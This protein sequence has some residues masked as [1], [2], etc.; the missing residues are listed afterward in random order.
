[1]H[2][3]KLVLRNFKK[4]RRAEIDFQDG[5]T[6]I[7]GSNGSGKSTIVEAIAWALYGN[8]VST[9]RREYLKNAHAGASE[10]VE[11]SLWLNWG[12]Q[13]MQVT[14]IMR[15]KS[16]SP[17]AELRL[18]G[19]PVAR[20][21]REVDQRLENILKIS[22]QDFMKTFYAR[23]KDLDNL[24]KEG[25]VGKREYLLK[26]LGLD[27]IRERGL[28]QI[29]E[30]IS[31]LKGQENRL[32]GA[33]QEIGDVGSRIEAV[34]TEIL[35][36]QDLLSQAEREESELAQ[37]LEQ[38]KRDL[39]VQS[40]K[41]HAHDL[42]QERISHLLE[43]AREKSD[44][45]AADEGL[46]Q[47]I[48]TSRR[49][50]EQLSPQLERLDFVRRRIEVLGPKSREHEKIWRHIAG[51]RAR[52]EATQRMLSEGEERL[53]SLHRDESVLMRL[54]PLEKE[55][56]ELQDQILELEDR[57]E[58]HYQQKSLLD[59]EKI[60]LAALRSNLDKN[61]NALEKLRQAQVRL[62]ELLPLKEKCI[63]L[64]EELQDQE[65]LSAKQKKADELSIRLSSLQDRQSKLDR[66]RT[67][68]QSQLQAL[69][70]LE[71][72]EEQLRKQDRE[73]DQLGSDLGRVLAELQASLKVQNL[74]RAE[75]QRN[76][77]R[78]QGLGGEAL[79]PTCER[80]L[81]EQR[82]M[83]LKKYRQSEKEAESQA[84]S[85]QVQMQA[86]KEKIESVATSRSRLRQ[87]FDEIQVGKSR[88]SELSATLR[89]VAAQIDEVTSELQD[90]SQ[91]L[92]GLGKIDFDPQRLEQIQEELANLVL[93]REECQSLEVRLEELPGK[94][95]DLQVLQDD[96]RHLTWTCANLARDLAILEYS[97]DE[98]LRV[99]KRLSELGPVH[100]RFVFLSRRVEDISAL[101]ERQSQ[102][103]AELQNLTGD[104]ATLERDLEAT[105][106][107]P[108]EYEALKGERQSLE[109][110]SLQAQS[111][112]IHLAAEPEI[113][114]RQNQSREA[115]AYLE[116][117]IKSARE[118]IASIGYSLPEHQ[119]VR[120]QFEAAEKE[121]EA[122]RKKVLQM[123]SKL[124]VL[125]RD[126]TLL[127]GEA[128][129]KDKN[130]QELLTVIRKLEVTESARLLINRFLDQVLIRIKDQIAIA[131][132]AILEEVSGKYGQIKID[133]NF[134][135]LVED[136]GEFYPISR[137]SGGEVDMIAVSVRVAISEYLMRFS[138]SKGYSFLILDE[139][140]GSQDQEHREKMI[141]MLRSLED[142]FPQVIAISHISDV[143]GQF[144]NALLVTEDE[145]GN[146]R[147][148][149]L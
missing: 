44:A 24:L 41:S 78:V 129:R 73:L 48:E 6:G 108:A 118:K 149:A 128:L 75:A 79:C 87:A 134:D 90:V 85:I 59:G 27:D 77:K 102:L 7:V 92:D 62:Q 29:R 101:L 121:L 110:A 137:Y 4:Y 120:S 84:A 107:D 2:L 83:L 113:Q 140:F 115:L 131:A 5:L 133:D 71:A 53:E 17:D 37:A 21:T 55:H 47:E 148:E 23:Q 25:G 141:Q 144:D 117:E 145:S 56:G 66:E 9:I 3:N 19:R 109:A 51:H 106:F 103:R 138:E 95:A 126:L 60:R 96:C 112:R 34:S 31:D 38:I 14:R 76:L 65:R 88:R 33:L 104:L 26:L 30:D 69:Q 119:A 142:R 100:Q 130:E 50:L 10:S 28:S 94:E 111:L 61:R 58:K 40:E 54:Q 86:Q 125:K 98:Y 91:R 12:R 32:R 16:Q 93:A 52:L 74:A 72:Q 123:N 13:E 127:N 99:K 35:A 1:M 116:E 97:E 132:G 15:G 81:G 57:R 82:E 36:A 22:Y 114:K 43:S 80:P 70:G 135:I 67:S 8:R 124:A 18:D 139:V 146:S 11:V 136:R 68:L 20:G 143:Q 63:R 105:G 147:T 64:Q 122:A 45:L 39:E 49:R 89:S 42:I 46:L